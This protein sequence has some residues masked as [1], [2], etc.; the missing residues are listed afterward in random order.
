LWLAPTHPTSGFVFRC[1]W[2]RNH[3]SGIQALFQSSSHIR[4]GS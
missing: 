2:T 4:V 3:D 1:S